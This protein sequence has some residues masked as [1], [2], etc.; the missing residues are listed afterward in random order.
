[1]QKINNIFLSCAFVVSLMVIDSQAQQVAPVTTAGNISGCQGTNCIPIPVTVSGF[2]KITALSL[3]MEFNASNI[4]FCSFE[5]VNTQLSGIIFGS[6]VLVSGTTYRLM[7][8][9]ANITPRTLT[10]GSKLFDVKFTLVNGSTVLSFNNTSNGGSDC[11]Y[12]DSTGNALPDTPTSTYYHNSSITINTL[13]VPSINGPATVCVNSAGNMYTT[14]PGMTNYIWTVSS[15]GTIT[16]GS[17]T[18]SITVTWSYPGTQTVCVN[19]TNS[20]GCS[21]ASPTCINV[22][23]NPLPVPTIT[24]P[25]SMCVSSGYYYYS[26]QAGMANYD[27]TISSGGTITA[28]LGTNLVQVIWN[29]PGQQF[30]CVNYTNA[31]GCEALMPTCINVSVNPLPSVAGPISGAPTVCVGDNGI[32]YTVDLIQNAMTYIW[33]L[34]PGSVIASGSGT[35]IITVNFEMNASSGNIIVYGNNVCGNGTPSPPFYISVN[36]LPVAAGVITGD[37][38]VC[39]GTGGVFFSVVPIPNAIGYVWNVPPGADIVAGNNT[40]SITVDFSMT[41]VSGNITVYG[42]NVCGSGPVSPDHFVAVNTIPPTPII[43]S[44]GDTLFSNATEGNNWYF[45]GNLIPGATGQTYITTQN[46]NYWDVVILNGCAS[47]TSN[48]IYISLVDVDQLNPEYGLA[49]YPVPN[50][51]S[52]MVSINNP[53]AD[54]FS[55]MVY[56]N[57]GIVIFNQDIFVTHG[58][59]RRNIDLRPVSPGIYSVVFRNKNTKVIKKILINVSS[60]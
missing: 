56:N 14:Q 60:M 11:E 43:S 9:W 1:M 8:S 51:G 52:F 53:D 27:W 50:N 38:I 26:T 57:L 12:A 4:T 28:G 46:G 40:N 58:N 31:N 59:I 49:L 5:N 25:T 34:P 17:G 2:Y 47:D 21:A 33:T 6:P 29:S 3:R 13:P 23:V 7:V 16:S 45:E 19:Y 22:T 24:G 42:T 37:S 20:Y 18:N 44:S 32:V 35:N 48:H 54:T 55:I 39:Q 41:S 10:S 36:P 30:I 15:G